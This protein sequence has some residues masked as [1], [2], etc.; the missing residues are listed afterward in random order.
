LPSATVD[1]VIAGVSHS[2]ASSCYPTDTTNPIQGIIFPDEK[3][4]ITTDTQAIFCC[5]TRQPLYATAQVIAQR[6]DPAND[7]VGHGGGGGFA[8]GGTIGQPDANAI[9]LT[10]GA[11]ELVGGFWSVPPCW[12]MSDLNNDGRRDGQDVQAFIACMLGAGSNCP[13][14]DMDENGVLN[15]SDMSTFVSGLL[16][17]A[18]CP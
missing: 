13:C 6:L 7:S 1:D 18:G 5:M 9:P 15:A 11:F 10:G 16:A 2:S 4:A 14:A 3:H 12:R 17:G 8:L